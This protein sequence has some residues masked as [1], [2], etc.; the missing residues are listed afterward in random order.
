[1]KKLTAILLCILM[2]FIASSCSRQNARD[3]DE[4]NL[5]EQENF[6]YIDNNFPITVRGVV[7]NQLPTKI[8]SFSP[9]LTEIMG[10]LGLENHMVGR[11]PYCEYS[12]YV[13]NL[14]VVGTMLMPDIPLLLQLLPE[15]I[16]TQTPLSDEL[17]QIL[18]DMGTKVVIIEKATDIDKVTEIY[19]DLFL[20]CRGS[21]YGLESAQAFNKQF[22]EDYLDAVMPATLSS[23]K[24]D[25]VYLSRE[26][27]PATPDTFENCIM[28]DMGL[29]NLAQG[30]NW[31][32]NQGDI[33]PK[34]ILAA[35][36]SDDAKIKESSAYSQSDAVKSNNIIKINFDPIERQ[37]PR[38]VREIKSVVSYI[39]ADSNYE[40]K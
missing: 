38:M 3:E 9:A 31:D 8:V 24:I 40:Q 29:N 32:A 18:S 1:M 13:E 27:N 10:E 30:T 17:N 26:L 11:T 7:I 12:D 28:Q 2:L 39:Y 14:P 36:E 20:M 19:T 22:K 25:T 33:N 35:L 4:K 21:E 6:A 15:Y 37:S 16:L 34:L 23:Q 5:Q